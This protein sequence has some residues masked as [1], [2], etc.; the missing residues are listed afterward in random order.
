MPDLSSGYNLPNPHGL[1]AD[2]FGHDME[3]YSTALKFLSDLSGG[4]EEA[5]AL[6]IN[7]GS[8]AQLRAWEQS[9]KFRRV[10]AKCRAAGEVER[11]TAERKRIEAEKVD[12]DMQPRPYGCATFVPLGKMPTR[13][14]FGS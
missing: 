14:I 6:E 9:S 12:E 13:Q 11:E 10:L 4:T 3:A 5:R 7:G 8:V 2:D 1:T